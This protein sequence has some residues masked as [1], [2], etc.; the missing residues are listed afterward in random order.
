MTINNFCSELWR[1]LL[2]STCHDQRRWLQDRG[3][4]TKRIQNR[5]NHFFVKPVFQSFSKVYDDE[6]QIIGVRRDELAMVREV[7]LYCGDTPVVFAHSAVA[8][9]NLRGVWRALNGLGNKSLGTM[10]FS[11][12]RIKRTPLEFKKIRRGHFLYDRACVYLQTKPTYLWARRSLFTLHGQSILV[13]EVFL[14][15]IL[16]LSS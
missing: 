16:H 1:A 13:T 2:I 11:N 7:F 10:L 8:R 15:S 4:L 14:P 12:P 5:C 6:L 3:S 9:K